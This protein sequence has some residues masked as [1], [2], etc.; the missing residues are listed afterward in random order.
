MQRM[1]Q[2]KYALVMFKSTVDLHLAED[3]QFEPLG[4][5]EL[6]I[7]LAFGIP[8]N[9]PLKDDIER[10]MSYLSQSGILEKLWRKWHVTRSEHQCVSRRSM[11]GM[12]LEQI[13]GGFILGG[14]GLVI[15]IISL[16]LENL[17][18]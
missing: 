5:Q 14:V 13:S 6:W 18:Q 3:C 4:A 12:T 2:Q 8:K 16:C 15:S 1:K 10:I 17:V 11:A 9:S 7:H